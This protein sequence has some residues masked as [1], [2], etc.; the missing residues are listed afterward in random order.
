MAGCQIEV[1]ERAGAMRVKD[2]AERKGQ[3]TASLGLDRYY[4][5]IEGPAAD[6]TD[7]LVLEMKQA[8]RS[9]LAGLTPPSHLELDGEGERIV[10]AHHL[11]VV[12]GDVFYGS[13]RRDDVSYMIRERAPY[14]DSVDLDD[15]DKGEWKAYARICGQALAQ[16]HALTDDADG[17]DVDIEPMI[18]EAIGRPELFVDDIVR[19]ALEAADRVRR[20]HEMFRADHE[21]GAFEDVDRV[22]D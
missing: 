20:D 21:L 8:R 15:L 17:I 18:V 5:L 16:T 6:G 7:D 14:R 1:P 10:E 11:Q 12:G 9:A 19:W 3:G 13:I 22:Y 4:L 2:V